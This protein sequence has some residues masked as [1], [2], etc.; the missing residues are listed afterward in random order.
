MDQIYISPVPDLTDDQTEAI[1]IIS[2]ALFPYIEAEHQSYQD[3]TVGLR[4]NTMIIGQFLRLERSLDV[5]QNYRSLVIEMVEDFE[6][7]GHYAVQLSETIKAL[8]SIQEQLAFAIGSL[9]E[10]DIEV[11]GSAKYSEALQSKASK[12]FDASVPEND[13]VQLELQLQ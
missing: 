9:F 3:F 1:N 4:P 6:E 10:V 5:L 2:E 12:L 11:F 7:L 8:N 13:C